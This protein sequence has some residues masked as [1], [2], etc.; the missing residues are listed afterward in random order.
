MNPCAKN[1]R[2]I[3]W[4]AA[5]VL[6]ETQAEALRPHLENCPG[7]R[8]YWNSL[9]NLAEQLVR[10]SDLPPAHLPP[11]FHERVGQKIQPRE[12]TAPLFHWV[13][14]RHWLFVERRLAAIAGV[15]VLGAGVLLGIQSLRGG[16]QHRSVETTTIHQAAPSV[17]PPHTLASYR[18]AAEISLENLD[19]L[20]AKE[21]T[22]NAS[23]MKTFTV[24]S[25][26]AQFSEK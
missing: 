21:G 12:K 10:A 4:M 20:L 23:E 16:K 18:R 22:G 25:L 6:D 5:G 9:C 7:C 11:S 13:G 2:R 26:S 17:T 8:S 24:S 15:I 3:A 19:T 14:L 1:K